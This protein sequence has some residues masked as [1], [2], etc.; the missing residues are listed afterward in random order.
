VVSVTTAGLQDDDDVPLSDPE[1]V[2]DPELL[3]PL[4]M[5]RFDNFKFS[6]VR[7]LPPV[8]L[9]DSLPFIFWFCL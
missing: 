8:R 9:F 7:L 3:L 4:M 1:P 5:P 6:A 2:V